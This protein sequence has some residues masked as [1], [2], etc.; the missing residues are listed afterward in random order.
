MSNLI[1]I[2]RSVT[3]A[4]PVGL[5]NGELAFTANGDVLFI[6]SPNGSTIAIGGLRTPGVL[7]ANQ[8]L[9]ANTTGYLDKI[10]VANIAPTQIWANGSFGSDG[11]LLTSNGSSIYWQTLPPGVV[12]ANTQLQF[13]DSGSLGAD[14]NLT[15]NK[16]TDTLTVGTTVQTTTVNAAIHSVGTA[17]VANATGLWTTGTVNA[18]VVSAGADVVANSSGVFTTG[19][20][21]AAVHTVGTSVVANSSGIWTTGTVNAVSHTIGTNVIANSSGVYT[22]G[23]VNAAILSVNRAFIVNNSTVE[24]GT[25]AALMA[26]GSI[27]TAGQVL[28][29]NGTGV[30]W[31]T[32]DQGVTSVATGSGLTGGIITTTGTVSVLANNGITANSTGLFVTEGTGLVVNSSGVH[33]NTA[34]IG[35][36]SANNATYLDGQLGSYY[37]NATNLATGTVPTARLGTGTANSVTFLSGDQTYKTAVT[38]VA[39]GNGLAGG[40]VTTSGTLSVQAGDG[41]VANATGTYVRAGTGVTVNS[42]GVHI[43]QPVAT[44]SNVTFADLTVNGNTKLGDAATDV[45]TYVGKVNTHILPSANVTY[46]LGNANE[47]WDYLYAGNVH[48]AFGYITGNLEV[49]GDLIVTGNLVTVNTS[50]LIVQD[51]LI[52]LAGNNYTSD[53][54]DIGFVGN[55]FDGAVSRHAG[56]IRHAD[57][58]EFYI[59]DNYAL[60]PNTNVIDISDPSFRLASLNTY[61]KSGALQS[62]STTVSITA[63]STVSVSITA[64]TLSLSAPLAGNS[65]GTG[66]NSITNN[67][68]LVGNS[69][70]GYTQLTL[71]ASGYVLQ[72][73]GTALVYDTLD[74]GSF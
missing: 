42:T 21:N 38:S 3:N 54:V 22:T 12:G 2:K 55:Y 70:N 51:P 62:N 57:N 44:T 5:A 65:G 20:V 24:I 48:S 58:E 1:Q 46:S 7:T 50:S 74:G 18:A 47:R 11:Q 28:H 69:S 53:L 10:L 30:Y 15:Y 9:V 23:T 29:S 27:G 49:G 4:N 40:P 64:N 66:I 41:I 32:D 36:L 37:T 31:G 19:T 6:G 13:N 16:D 67:A 52:Y 45:V 61:L 59:F 35:T 56:V 33:V 17:L 68:I 63:N 8:A 72:S 71:G 39:S 26:N 60:E 73:N 34:Y 25:S 43:G 14:A